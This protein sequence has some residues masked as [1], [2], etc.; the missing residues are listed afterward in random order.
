MGCRA[1]TWTKAQIELL[2]RTDPP[3]P[4]P[5]DGQLEKGTVAAPP[6]VGRDPSTGKFLPGHQFS[7]GNKGGGFGIRAGGAA[8]IRI[9]RDVVTPDHVERICMRAVEQAIAGDEPARRF[10]FE[11]V[12]GKP[13][14][15]VEEINANLVELLRAWRSTPTEATDDDGST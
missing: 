7:V 8:W 3:Q 2:E 15:R 4:E 6:E 5:E 9:M 13:V 14:Q 10:L 11:Y 1:T 12:V